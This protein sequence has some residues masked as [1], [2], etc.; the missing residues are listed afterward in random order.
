MEIEAAGRITKGASKKLTASNAPPAPT[1]NGFSAIN[2]VDITNGE[3]P[4]QQSPAPPLQTAAP[5]A[6]KKRKQPGSSAA[7]SGTTTPFS[8]GQRHQPAQLPHYVASNMLSFT[9]CAGRLNTKK[10]LVANDGTALAA[11]GE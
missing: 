5:T 10:Q 8:L 11:D 7:A 9:K 2:S 1:E 3:A 6:S 4:V